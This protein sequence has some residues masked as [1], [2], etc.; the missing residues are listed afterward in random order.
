MMA[1]QPAVK[2]SFSL[3]MTIDAKAH[4]EIHALKPIELSDISVTSHTVDLPP[5][6]MGQVLELDVVRNKEDSDPG[7]RVLRIQVLL[8]FHYLRVS[9]YD[10]F[11][12][13]KALLHL[14]QS[15][16]LR[17]LD[18]G[19]TKATIYLLHSRVHPVAEIDGLLR[20]DFLIRIEI[21]EVEQS[22]DRQTGCRKPSIP[23]HRSLFFLFAC[24]GHIVTLSEKEVHVS[25]NRRLEPGGLPP[26]KN[27]SGAD[28]F[29]A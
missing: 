24:L 11:M 28:D 10:V 19:V 16:M 3:L 29:Y 13:E 17:P 8:F 5:V 21:V 15:R 7:N 6:H 26:G 9:R 18:I 27:W 1:R 23:F 25:G 2:L 14:G 4:F 20:T 12:T 22:H